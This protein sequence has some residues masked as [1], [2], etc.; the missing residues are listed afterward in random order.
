MKIY[1]R[2]GMRGSE[3]WK[4]KSKKEERGEKVDQ[5]QIKEEGMKGDGEKCRRGGIRDTGGGREDEGK[6]W[7]LLKGKKWSFLLYCCEGNT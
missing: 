4:E 2:K 6:K 7:G 5:K 1:E 3:Q